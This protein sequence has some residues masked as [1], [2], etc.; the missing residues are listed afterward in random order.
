M[1]ELIDMPNLSHNLTVLNQSHP[2]E[3]QSIPHL[4]WMSFSPIL[5]VHSI[6][7]N[8]AL[9]GYDPRGDPHMIDQYV[10]SLQ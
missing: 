10:R 3:I 5:Q 4:G 1:Y 9:V 7:L 8:Y 6:C 2:L